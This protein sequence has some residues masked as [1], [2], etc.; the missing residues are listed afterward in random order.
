MQSLVVILCVNAAL[1]ATIYVASGDALHG[2][3]L[4]VGGAGVLFSLVL[5]V[6]LDLFSAPTAEP[7]SP[8]ADKSPA[9]SDESAETPAPP[10]PA[11]AVQMLS[12][13]QRKGRLIDFLQED[14][15]AYDDAQI[16]AA[17]RNV[18]A[19]CREAL[20]EHVDLEPILDEPESSTVTIEDGFDAHQIRLTGDVT[21][22]PPFQG[23]LRHHG[24]R[25]TRLDLPQQMQSKN[26]NRVVAAAEVELP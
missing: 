17:A 9:T 2:Q 13:L 25:V 3:E 1:L 16:G 12:I 19:G 22:D 26:E 6:V 4:L 18:H 14:I 23:T 10:S 5:W 24:W 11:A 21:G 20:Q 7:D 15:Q 8:E